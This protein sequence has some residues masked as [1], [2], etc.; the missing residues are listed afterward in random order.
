MS[1][2]NNQDSICKIIVIDNGSTDGTIEHIRRF[3]PNIELIIN[4]INRGFG[5]SNNQAL[6]LCLKNN[7]DYA[8]LLNQDAWIENGVL[9]KLIAIHKNNPQYGILSP[10]HLRGDGDALDMKFAAFVAQS[11]NHKLIS[12][13][14]LKRPKMDDIYDVQFVNAAAW[15]IPKECFENVGGFAPIYHHY[16][17]D[18]DYANRVLYHGFKIGICP[19]TIIYHD[20]INRIVLPN[21]KRPKEYLKLKKL[22]HLIYLTDIN[23]SFVS[24][25]LKLLTIVCLDCIKSLLSLHLNDMWNYLKEFWILITLWPKVVR[26]N[27]CTRKKGSIFLKDFTKLETN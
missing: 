4:R 26:N 15:L 27:F 12:D 10:I 19:S 22:W 16:G 3:F 20:R 18:M 17:E 25:F 5:Y 11:E 8:F 13:L 7:V 6:Q 9:E 21:I 23:H 2:L 14:Y 24:R 1:S